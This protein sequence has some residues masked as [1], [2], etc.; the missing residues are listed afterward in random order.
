[1]RQNRS[2]VGRKSPRTAAKRHGPD[3]ARR[4]RHTPGDVADRKAGQDRDLQVTANKVN[5]VA[6]TE[7]PC[8]D[9]GPR[10]RTRKVAQNDGS[11]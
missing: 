5:C 11:L 7:V 4:N 9:T 3:N 1:M 2:N 6:Q 8:P 10:F